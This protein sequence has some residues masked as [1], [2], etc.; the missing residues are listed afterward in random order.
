MNILFSL[1]RLDVG[2]AQ[3]LAIMLASRL[4]ENKDH[5]L[6]LYNHTP[7]V[8]EKGMLET[9]MSPKIK[10]LSINNLKVINFISWK[11]NAFFKSIGVNFASREYLR[12]WY[13]LYCLRKYKIDVVSSHLLISDRIC[14]KLLTGN[15]TP[16]VVT[17]HGE[18]NYEL[19]KVNHTKKDLE[20]IFKRTNVI[21]AVSEYQKKIIAD[22]SEIAREKV[23][24]IYNGIVLNKRN[25]K[26]KACTQLGIPSDAFVF[27]MV[28]RGVPEKGWRETVESFKQVKLNT[29]INIHLILVGEGAILTSLQ[30]ENSAFADSI[31]FVGYSKEPGFWIESFHVGLLPSYGD[32]L[33]NA[34]IEYIAYKKPVIATRVGGIPEIINNKDTECGLMVDLTVDGKPCL[35]QLQ[36]HMLTYLHDSNIYREH[37]Q[38]TEEAIKRFDVHTFISAYEKLFAEVREN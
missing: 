14:T 20:Q 1:G 34:V 7:D 36:Q 9:L 12:N 11:L 32:A 5:T 6:F 13:F 22:A 19:N 15:T 17:E 16:I 21:V 26:Y 30:K 10:Y 23:R 4:A 31:H 37:S 8:V 35:K 25:F 28:A 18:Y 33:P 2:G 29:L 27:G 3:T 24:L 38:K